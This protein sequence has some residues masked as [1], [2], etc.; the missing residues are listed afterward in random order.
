[1]QLKTISIK[2][3]L[4]NKGIEYKEANGELIADCLFCN[5]T[6]HLYFSAETGQY[7][8]KVCGA[9]G[10]IVTLSKHLG[11][12]I[13]DIAQDK[14]EV[15]TPKTTKRTQID[16]SLVNSCHQT[17]PANIRAYLVAR[18][19]N[20]ELI[21]KYKL[22][23]GRFYGKQWITIPIKDSE[24]D[25]SFFKLRQD[26]AQGNDK[27]TYPK[28]IE[29]QIYDWEE[30]NNNQESIMICEGEGDRLALLSQG[31][32]AIT[33]THGAMTFKQEWVDKI[34]TKYK[35]IYI[36]FDN[37]EA[38]QK[39]AIRVAK[40]LENSDCEVYIITLPDEVGPG[41]DITDYLTKLNGNID[42][43]F[44]KYAKEY[45]EKIDCSQFDILS[46]ETLIEILGLT[47]K[48]D[49][50]N[51]LIAFLCELSAYTE[52]S[53][54][55]IS[56]N[57]PSST[58]KSYI[59]TEVA[60][61]FPPEDILEIG[62]CSPT[63]F[64]HDAGEFNKEING[65]LVDLSRKIM[66]FLDQ[67]HTLLLQHLRPLLSHDKKEISIK[68]T[69][70]SQKNGLK[71]KNIFLR[72]FPAVVFCTAGLKIDEQET[73]RFLLLSPETN[74]EKVREAIN[75]KIKKETNGE[76]Y[77]SILESDPG[78]I[79][80]KERIKAIKQA[81]VKEIK[82]GSPEKITEAFFTKNKILKP[83]NQ[84]DI[85]RIIS[86][87]KAFAL[88]NLWFRE[89]VG[90]TIIANED[91]I[92]QA[93]LVWDSISESQELNLPPFIY[94][95]YKEVIL[96]AWENKGYKGLSRKEISKEHLRIYGRILADWVL[97]QQIIPMLE[98]SGLISQE[99]D[100]NDKRK[101]LIC[102]INNS[103]NNNI[104]NHGELGGGVDI[105]ENNSELGGG[106]NFN[107]SLF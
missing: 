41:G 43:L 92:K 71:T 28:G 68:I 60:Q 102:P 24:G 72:G 19:I 57:A 22:G 77:R 53:Q 30:L 96:P 48:K 14:Q 8:C 94:Q 81:K 76:L 31:I 97:R 36:C 63:A 85:G 103:E 56:F 67:P 106:V 23:W 100:L 83:R 40:M 55:N 104:E 95:I 75:Q 70:K 18:G 27:I 11:D 64:F 69:D 4:N 26:P 62:Y 50:T 54:L 105:P 32:P 59:P 25:Y 29:A 3:Y 13:S 51:K 9:Q 74:S 35:K 88:L 87:I 89:K 49:E 12:K 6:K 15:L 98:N 45:P 21:D 39:G 101:I 17:L 44:Y 2:D 90:S 10:N 79:M 1:M 42:D 65:Y 37:D 84:R 78:R 58:G 86:L 107:D 33:S 34:S 91:D 80:L 93:F 38:G 82:I 46:S 5:K 66:I 20:N 47:I 73:T 52:S 16:E 61:L 99:A 7:D